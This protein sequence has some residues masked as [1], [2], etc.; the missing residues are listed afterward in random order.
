MKTKALL[1]TLCG[2][3][4]AAGLRAQDK[5]LPPS[6]MKFTEEGWDFKEIKEEAGNV[7]HTF[8]FTNTGKEPFVIEKVTTTCGC[9]TPEYTKAPILPGQKGTLK[10]TFN[11]E[12]RPGSFRKTI[13]VT[14]NSSQNRNQIYIKGSVIP[15]PRTPQEEF[16]VEVGGG[17][18]IERQSVGLGYLPRGATKSVA[19]QYMNDSPVSISLGALYKSP[20]NYFRVVFA[21][22]TVPAGGRGLLTL[23]YDL[24]SEDIWGR[25][26]D[27]FS[28]TVDGK[29]MAAPFSATGIAT[30]DYSAWTSAQIEAAA[31]ADFSGQYYHF[32]DVRQGTRVRH[33]F[34]I[35]NAGKAPLVIQYI[36]PGANTTLT[37]RQGTS[38]APGEVITFSATVD[39]KGVAPGRFMDASVIIVNDP[40][41]PMRELRLAATIQ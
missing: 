24:R 7:S 29:R 35:T 14:S 26:S 23:T 34:T 19:I 17:L 6:T 2:L 37:L 27:E 15:Q 20:N 18:R 39:T 21:P 22:E 41:R 30:D 25:T 36:K 5:P 13:T 9:T 10:V 4:L 38:L 28:I 32:G 1:L 8:T 33:D 31:K 40:Q 16:P 3:W 11:P 12:G